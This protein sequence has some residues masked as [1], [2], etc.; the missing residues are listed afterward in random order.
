M[1]ALGA[2]LATMVVGCGDDGGSAASSREITVFAA[3]SLTDAFTELAEAFED[4][5][6]GTSATL[7]FGPSSG[8]REQIL[9]GAPVDV[10]ASADGADMDR[11][12]AAGEVGEPRVFARNSLMIAVPAGNPGEVTGLADFGEGHLLI[13]LCAEEVPCGRLARRALTGAG[14]VPD[15]DT[16]AADA[17]ALLT[18]IASGDLDAGIVYRTDVAAAGDDVE[19]VAIRGA[20]NVVAEYP[21]AV[22]TRAESSDT[23]RAFVDFALSD[24]AAAIVTGKGFLGP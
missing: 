15:L 21:I 13:G 7:S 24:D 1:L 16:N 4:A 18:Q 3:A 19:G 23:A 22:L 14:V 12:A 2:A 6:P 10:Y 5:N 20:F 9:A 17:R 11:L 8:L